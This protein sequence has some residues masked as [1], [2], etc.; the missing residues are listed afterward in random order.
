MGAMRAMVRGDP[1]PWTSPTY[2]VGEQ[3]G[4]ARHGCGKR[5]KSRKR[6]EFPEELSKLSEG[7]CSRGPCVPLVRKGRSG[8]LD[9][10][11]LQSGGAVGSRP[12]P[13]SASGRN[14][15][16]TVNFT[17]LSQTFRGEEQFRGPR[18]RSE[19]EIRSP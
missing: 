8:L 10:S 13:D 17:R 3:C 7:K 19:K 16:N 18:P 2:R 14:S 4:A 15:E 11:N 12:S 5:L 9:F 1:G 6:G